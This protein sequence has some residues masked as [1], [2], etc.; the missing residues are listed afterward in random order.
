MGATF[1]PG[2]RKLYKDRFV[3]SINGQLRNKVTRRNLKELLGK[4]RASIFRSGIGQIT[5]D[6]RDHGTKHNPNFDHNAMND[7]WLLCE[8]PFFPN[9]HLGALWKS[10]GVSGSP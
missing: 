8:V 3:D 10:H 1:D 9:R 7:C 4:A 6:A 2:Y 5:D